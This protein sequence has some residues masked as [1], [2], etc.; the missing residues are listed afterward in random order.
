METKTVQI[1]KNAHKKLLKIRHI[2]EDR[3]SRAV[4]LTKTLDRVI[5][6]YYEMLTK[7]GSE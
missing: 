6:A 2:L 1:S 3:E 4:S 7:N 5:D